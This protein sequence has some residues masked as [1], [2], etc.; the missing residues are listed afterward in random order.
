MKISPFAAI[1]LVVTI[2][3]LFSKEYHV[4]I[5]GADD[6][7]GT[8]NKPFRSI[9]HAARIAQTGDVIIVHQGV[10]REKIVLARGGI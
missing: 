10:Y 6:I 9:S 3:F 4:S 5:K 1:L 2:N 8:F 7:N